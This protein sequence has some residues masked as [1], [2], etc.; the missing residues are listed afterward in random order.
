MRLAL[1]PVETRGRE[2]PTRHS[3]GFHVD[4]PPQECTH[5]RCR[6]LVGRPFPPAVK[7]PTPLPHLPEEM[8]TLDPSEVVVTRTRVPERSV[9][10]PFAVGAA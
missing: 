10:A 5:A 6:E 4:S 8:D 3:R 7:Q 2:S 1:G 9:A